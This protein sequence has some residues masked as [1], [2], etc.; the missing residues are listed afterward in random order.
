MVSLTEIARSTPKSM[1]QLT[2]AS[3]RCPIKCARKELEPESAFMMRV[4]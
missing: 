4:I 2:I 1:L 3:F